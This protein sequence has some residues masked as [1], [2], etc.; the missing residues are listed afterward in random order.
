MPL[1]PTCPRQ[2]SSQCYKLTIQGNASKLLGAS[3]SLR[4]AWIVQNFGIRLFSLLGWLQDRDTRD[5]HWI[6]PAM[7]LA[8]WSRYT[9]QPYR[10]TA[11]ARNDDGLLVISWVFI[12]WNFCTVLSSLSRATY[13][14]RAKMS[15]S[16]K[17]WSH[18]TTQE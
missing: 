17:G 12:R 18:L 1:I 15:V 3:M 8:G 14:P 2:W 5:M 11:P 13:G 6:A 7:T 10:V 9:G 16:C 4:I